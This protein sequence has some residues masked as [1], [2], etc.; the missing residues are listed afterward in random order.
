[1]RVVF[2]VLLAFSLSGC[3]A[4]MAPLNRV[5]D[6]V[7]D[8]NLSSRFGQLDVALRH[9]EASARPDYLSRRATWGHSIRILEIETAG[10]T[11]DDEAHATVVIEVAW[12]SVEDSLLRTTNVRQ[13]WENRK[14]GW[15]LMRERRLSGE[16]GLFG[17]TLTQL[18]PPHPDVH[19]P[20]RTLGN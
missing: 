13:D 19:R 4:G 20:S 2:A 17:E 16:P 8:T 11:L 7:R 12:S 18:Q 3:F 9:V 5:S 14:T 15:L 6:A 1:M 10:I